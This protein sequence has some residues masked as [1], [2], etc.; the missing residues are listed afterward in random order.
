MSAAPQVTR[1]LPSLA[2]KPAAFSLR[3]IGAM[4]MRHVYVLRTS[5][6]RLF[7]LAY[8]PTLQMVL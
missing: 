6:P 7:E 1:G 3:R 2:P 8:W 4:V 5:W